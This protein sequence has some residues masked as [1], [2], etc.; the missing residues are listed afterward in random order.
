MID[1]FLEKTPCK[2]F[3][4]EFTIIQLRVTSFCDVKFFHFHLFRL[5]VAKLHVI[6][7]GIFLGKNENLLKRKMDKKNTLSNNGKVIILITKRISLHCCESLYGTLS[8]D[9]N[10]RPCTPINKAE[11]ALSFS[12]MVKLRCYKYIYIKA[13]IPLYD[14]DLSATEVEKYSP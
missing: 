2:L 11:I 12:L 10:V 4:H 9:S 1:I 8:A 7:V 3:F 6:L 13:A 14:E 5:L